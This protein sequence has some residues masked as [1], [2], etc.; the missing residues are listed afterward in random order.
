MKDS[1]EEEKI[2]HGNVIFAKKIGKVPTQELR[3]ICWNHKV[4]ELG[5]SEGHF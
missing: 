2:F 3:L 4:R 1:V 5:M